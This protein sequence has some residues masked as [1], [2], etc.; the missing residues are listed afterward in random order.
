MAAN[1]ALCIVMSAPRIYCWLRI[2]SLVFLI[3][4]S[5]GWWKTMTRTSQW[6]LVGHMAT[7]HQVGVPRL[8]SS[9]ELLPFLSCTKWMNTVGHQLVAWQ[10]C[11]KHMWKCRVC[12]HRSSHRE[13]WCL[14]LWRH[15]LGASERA[16][17]RRL[18]VFWGTYQLG[19][20]GKRYDPRAAKLYMR[21]KR[22][23]FRLV[24]EGSQDNLKL[25]FGIDILFLIPGTKFARER[26][27]AGGSGQASTRDS[28]APGA[29][30]SCGDCL[31][32]RLSDAGWASP[33][34]PSGAVPGASCWLREY[35]ITLAY[36]LHRQNLPEDVK[37]GA[38]PEDIKCGAC[39][40]SLKL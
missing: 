19:W 12:T 13:V 9:A 14:Q 26:S 32:M 3:L 38:L 7:L 27:G 36:S 33:Y 34:G 31:Q 37:C 29:R 1:V 17:A 4:A 24:F 2:L 11:W 25:Q 16:Q 10:Y 30:N 18:F 22:G 15:S 39:I 8:E 5:P 6:P 40:G 23:L 20:L 35:T 21:I 28:T